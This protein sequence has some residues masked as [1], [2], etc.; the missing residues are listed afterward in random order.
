M[1]IERR[2]SS[3][4]I[5]FPVSPLSSSYISSLI[6]TSVVFW[7]LSATLL[8]LRLYTRTFIVKALGWDDFAMIIAVVC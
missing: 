1:L 4:E 5:D 3:S 8:C 7:I 6:V 2:Q